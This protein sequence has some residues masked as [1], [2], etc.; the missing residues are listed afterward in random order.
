[1]KILAI[2]TS[3]WAGNVTLTENERLLAAIVVST[4]ISHVKDIF[5]AIEFLLAQTS[6]RF[7]DLDA[8]AFAHGPGSFTGLRIGISI[9][10][11]LAY[12][13]QKP[14]VGV[15]TLRALALNLPFTPALICPLLDARKGEV[16]TALYRHNDQG[17]LIRLAEAM[18]VTPAEIMARIQQIGGPVIFIGDGNITYRDQLKAALPGQCDFAPANLADFT[19]Y[20]IAQVAWRELLAGP[21][22]AT[23]YQLQPQYI[24]RPEAEIKRLAAGLKIT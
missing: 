5:A 13:L 14:V 17:E 21:A 24:R 11:G 18:V 15:D 9:V 2:D 16:Y 3:T 12:S 23:L 10:K 4:R 6:L 19:G 7:A 1:V 8:L 22:P 20:Q